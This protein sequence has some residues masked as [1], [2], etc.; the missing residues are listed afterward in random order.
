[1]LSSFFSL[2]LRIPDTHFGQLRIIA[3]YRF[4]G[5]FETGR[6][7]HVQ[8]GIVF[9]QLFITPQYFLRFRLGLL[10]LR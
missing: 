5:R 4:L 8:L 2:F 9:T 1:M 7:G 3:H 6:L 10:Q